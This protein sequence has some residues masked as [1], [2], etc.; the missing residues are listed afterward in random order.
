MVPSDHGF[1]RLD[2][3]LDSRFGT[4]FVEELYF[5]IMEVDIL[6]PQLIVEVRLGG[7]WKLDYPQPIIRSE[8]SLSISIWF[9]VSLKY[10]GSENWIQSIIQCFIQLII[11][12]IFLMIRK[13]ETAVKMNAKNTHEL[14]FMLLKLMRRN[15]QIWIGSIT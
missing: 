10:L 5:H 7:C 11:R 4:G 12:A 1:A 2:A 3:V 15:I 13:F 6:F 14:Y 8:S 9:F